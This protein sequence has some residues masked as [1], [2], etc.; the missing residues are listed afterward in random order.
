MIKN[1]PADANRENSH[2]K[3]SDIRVQHPGRNQH[4]HQDQHH[5]CEEQVCFLAA[6]AALIVLERVERN[7]VAQTLDQWEDC[8]QG[9]GD[10]HYQ[11]H[12]GGKHDA[13]EDVDQVMVMF[14]SGHWKEMKREE[15]EFARN[16]E[17]G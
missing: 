15:S 13:T 6:Q 5:A 16:R 4:R 17:L 2:D 10:V 3:N 9:E 8:C 7:V 11:A 1:V 12:G 14:F